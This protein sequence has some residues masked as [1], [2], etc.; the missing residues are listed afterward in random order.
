MACELSKLFDV[1]FSVSVS[2]WIV[3][4]IRISFQMTGN[5]IQ[6][7]H[8]KVMEE[9]IDFGRKVML[10]GQQ[11]IRKQYHL[12]LWCTNAHKVCSS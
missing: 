5:S 8:R 1:S 11:Q 9:S 4:T 7:N 6:N 12:F 3:L 10:V 2:F